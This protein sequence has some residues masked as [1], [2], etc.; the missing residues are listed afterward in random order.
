[1]AA[2]W[3]NC[4]GDLTCTPVRVAAPADE[5]G[6]VDAVRRA[7]ADGLVVRPC[8]TGHSFTPLCVTDGV[9]LDLRGLSRLVDLDADGVA[10][11][12]AGMTLHDLS[13]ALHAHGRALENLG[14]IDKQTVS[15][16]LATA[17]HG[18]GAAFGNL[19]TQ[20]VG[21]R[22][23]TADGSVLDV[24]MLTLMYAGLFAVAAWLF[25]RASR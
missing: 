11:V 6:V 22:L 12:Q 20:M 8:G 21:G 3:Q 15:G 23:V 16:A 10:R 5:A 17:T 14:D 9:Q 24:L 1:V 2:R 25:T 13:L 18:T 7:A 19:S 4:S